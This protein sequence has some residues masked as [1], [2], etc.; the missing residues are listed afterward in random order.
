MN[1]K[2][3][4]LR[5]VGKRMRGFIW[6]EVITKI[7]WCFVKRVRCWYIVVPMYIDVLSMCT[8]DYV[9]CFIEK[10]LI[11]KLVCVIHSCLWHVYLLILVYENCIFFVYYYW[12][13]CLSFLCVN[14]YLLY[15]MSCLEYFYIFL[16]VILV[17]FEYKI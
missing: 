7:L 12:L 11:T 4:M 3:Y 5:L 8:A 14:L 16:F 6:L 13:H 15:S 17:E 2:L 10:F 1:L 9:A